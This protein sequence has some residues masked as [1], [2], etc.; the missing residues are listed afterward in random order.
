M[1]EGRA[2]EVGKL[3]TLFD[4]HNRP[5]FRY[6]MHLTGNRAGSEDLGQEACLR[7]LK[8]RRGYQAEMSFRS[9]MYQSGRSVYLDQAGKSK[10]EV[11]L[12]ED[13][14]ELGSADTPADRQVQKKQET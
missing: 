2:G 8:Y 12:P 14:F 6:F 1:Q 9:W 10:G 11:M 13:A 4:R 3:A 7:I 5:L